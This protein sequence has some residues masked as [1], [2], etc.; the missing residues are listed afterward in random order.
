MKKII[1][2]LFVLVTQF[3]YAQ[4]TIDLSDF[5]DVKVFDKLNVTLIA[6]SENRAVVTGTNQ[7]EVE[8]VNKRGLLKIRMDV[9]KLMSGDGLKVTLYFKKI[10]SIDA[11]EGSV[12]ICED[13]FKQ[14]TLDLATQEG[15]QITAILDVDKTKIKAYSGGIINVSGKAVTQSV[16]I[17]SGGILKASELETSQTTVSISAGGNAEILAST[18]VDAKVKAGGDIIIYGKPKQILQETLLGGRITEKQ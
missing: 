16:I 14:T 15:A 4:T 6:S 11:N 8:L 12:V 5:D 1:L 13:T 7:S 10:Q 18:L 2:L 9:T 3:N 17:N